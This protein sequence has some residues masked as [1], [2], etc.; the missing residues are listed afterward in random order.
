MIKKYFNILQ[1]Q[2]L[3]GIS[4]ENKFEYLID[5]LPSL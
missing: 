2:I 5:T 4:E 3:W 1:M